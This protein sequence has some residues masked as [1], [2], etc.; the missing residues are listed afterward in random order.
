MCPKMAV[1]MY[2]RVIVCV[3]VWGGLRRNHVC[4][5]VR[6]S[7]CGYVR[8]CLCVCV[9][10]NVDERGTSVSASH[11]CA[12]LRVGVRVR[13]RACMSLCVCDCRSVCTRGGG[14]GAFLVPCSACVHRAVCARGHARR[15]GA[16]WCAP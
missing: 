15:E 13:V 3:V 11:L 2:L 14:R 8:E 12:C 6:V 9:F 1:F 4:V 10:V 7:M 16:S 5:C